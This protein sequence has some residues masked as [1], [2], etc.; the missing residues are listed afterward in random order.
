M[1][2]RGGVGKRLVDPGHSTFSFAN[3]LVSKLATCSKVQSNGERRGGA[4]GEGALG[5]YA[6]RDSNPRPSGP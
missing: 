3:S 4:R 5:E 6:R 2:R 1:C